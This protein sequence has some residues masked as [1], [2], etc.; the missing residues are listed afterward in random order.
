MNFSILINFIYNENIIKTI[1]P[2]NIISQFFM[3]TICFSDLKLIQDVEP[4]DDDDDD[5]KKKKDTE[6]RE[7]KKEAELNKN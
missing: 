4:S 1:K 5:R 3:I 6:K 7:R 2:F